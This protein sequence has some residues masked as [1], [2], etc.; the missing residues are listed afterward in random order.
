[1]EVWAFAFGV[2]G[3][4]AGVVGVV[5][6]IAAY[7]A[8]GTADRVAREANDLSRESNEIARDARQRAEE[9]NEYSHRA[10]QRDTERHHV[11]WEGYWEKPGI[12]V[13]VK[14]GSDE[15]HRVV[16]SVTADGEEQ[17]QAADLVVD[18]GSQFL[19]KFDK[20]YRMFRSEVEA[21]RKKL[22]DAA[23]ANPYM[24]SLASTM[25]FDAH[26]VEIRVQWSTAQG[27]P[28]KFEPKRATTSFARFYPKFTK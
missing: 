15:A 28:E 25:I 26:P 4:V 10:E 5:I 19:F 20:S 2:V 13:L 9:A 22:Q 24:P 18:D 1:M 8:S 23:A 21:H 12:Y 6:A 7:S 16:A 14:R 11:H 17:T 3:S 27:R